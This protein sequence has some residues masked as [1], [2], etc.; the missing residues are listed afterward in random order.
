MNALA[1]T[2]PLPQRDHFGR[3]LLI[4]AALEAVL[5]GGLLWLGAHIPAPKPLPVEKKIIAVHMVQPAPFI[6]KPI[7]PAPKPVVQPKPVPK[8][9][10]KAIV[11]EP[12]P[13]PVMHP[14]PAPKPLLA[15]TPA[16]TAPVYTPPAPTPPAPP[17]PPAPSPA[18]QQ[19]AIASYAGLLRAR[20]Q[21]DTRVPEAVRLMHTSGTALISFRLTPSGQLLSARVAQSS[22]VGPIDRA[23][24]R[25]VQGGSY[26]PFTKDMPKHVM[27]FAVQ[28][29]L[30]A[31]QDE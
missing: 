31:H 6:P 22:G 20:V 21:A 27:A 24:L 11:H 3:A 18:T 26:P 1:N 30:S 25:A 4:G 16:P 7:P 8:P 19:D 29:H 28:V 17:P 5:V 23:A 13:K 14:T 10:P 12:T 2:T 9:V 15:K